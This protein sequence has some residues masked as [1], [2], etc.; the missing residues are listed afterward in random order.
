M[1]TVTCYIYAFQPNTSDLASERCHAHLSVTLTSSFNIT[2]TANQN[3]GSNKE[4]AVVTADARTLLLV[5]SY[6][7]EGAKSRP[8]AS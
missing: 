6:L 5:A 1:F 4:P 2:Y 7:L 3:P 8:L